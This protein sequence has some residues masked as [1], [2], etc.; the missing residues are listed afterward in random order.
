MQRQVLYTSIHVL[1]LGLLKCVIPWFSAHLSEEESQSILHFLTLKDSFPKKIFPRL[2]LQWLPFGYSD[3]TSVGSSWKQLFA[4]LCFFKR[5]KSST[6][7]MLPAAGDMYK[8]PYSSRMLFSGNLRSRHLHMDDPFTMDRK[9]IDLLFFFHKA[10]K[11]DLDYLVSGSARLASDSSFLMEFQQRFHLIKLFYQIHSNAEDEIAFPAP[12]AKGKLQ[13]ITHSFSIDHELETKHFDKVSLILN[14]MSELNMLVSTMKYERLCL[15]LQEICRSMH[16]ILSEHFKQEETELWCLFRGCFTIEEQEKIIGCMLGRISGET[17]KDMIPWLMD[18]LTSDEQHDA[19]SLWLQATRGTMFVDW[20]NEWYNGHI[21]K[22]EAREANNI[23]YEHLKHIEKM[24]CMKCLMIQPIGANCSNASCKSSIGSYFCKICKLFDD[25][26]SIYH[27]PYCNLCRVGEGLGIDYFHCMKCNA[28]LS[29]SLK[30]HVCRENWL[31]VDCPICCEYIFT[32]RTVIKPL[33]CGHLMHSACF[34]EY[35]RS[36]YTCPVCSKSLGDMKSYFK[37]LDELLAEEKMPDE[38]S[39]KTQVILCN[40]CG[41]K[42]YRKCTSCGSY[43]S[44]LL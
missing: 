23:K 32:S 35:T 29:C 34:Q 43:N 14:E 7:F 28:C 39:N 20:L 30:E 44:K 16:K 21:I 15:S 6:F 11:V 27:C 31:E 8:T 25:E 10:M 26:R 3:K 5:N 19:M 13:K 38:Y 1:P 41:R 33:P 12:E 40:D 37:M 4:M 36:N 42:G 2:L 17:L 9:P 24:M 18:S 22:E